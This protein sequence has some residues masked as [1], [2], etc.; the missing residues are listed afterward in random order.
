M[1][2]TPGPPPLLGHRFTLGG[3]ARVHKAELTA[4]WYSIQQT[5]LP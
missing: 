5:V 2:R 3:Q 4:W 1:Y